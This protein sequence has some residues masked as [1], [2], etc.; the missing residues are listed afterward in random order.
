MKK[1]IQTQQEKYHY[2]MQ[3]VV[4]FSLLLI[5]NIVNLPAVPK[6]LHKV[7][8]LGI[9]SGTKTTVTNS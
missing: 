6:K 8:L 1:D 4:V 5:L 7:C 2:Y 9:H 3:K